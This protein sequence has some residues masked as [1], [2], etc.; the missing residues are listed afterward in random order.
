VRSAAHTGV[1]QVQGAAKVGQRPEA[2]EP[3]PLGAHR[4]DPQRR[5][6]QPDARV[7]EG[8]GLGGEGRGV[9]GGRKAE[10]VS[11]VCGQSGVGTELCVER[12]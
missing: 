7:T 11:I 2:H 8:N 1:H 9:G 3:R 12:A 6:L 10:L 5:L 4:P